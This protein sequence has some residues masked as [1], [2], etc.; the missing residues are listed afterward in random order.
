M[1]KPIATIGCVRYLN[2]RPLVAGLEE[3]PGFRITNDVPSRL[4]AGLESEQTVVAL[5]PVIDY[6]TSSSRL[7]IVPAGAIGS[8][9]ETLTVRAFAD[10][11]FSE[12]ESVAVDGDSRTSVALLQLLL[13]ELYGTRPALQPLAKDSLHRGLPD[14]VDAILLIGD[15]VVTAAPLLPYQLDLGEVWKRLT[16]QPFV[17]ATWM[18]LEATDLDGIPE[19]LRRCREANR[20]MIGRI[21][22]A[23]AGPAGW[24]H[25]LARHYL[26]DVLRY[27]IGQR[28]LKAITTFWTRCHEIGLIQDLRPL[29]LYSGGTVRTRPTESS[30]QPV[31]STE[32]P[33]DRR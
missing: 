14:G 5:C 4:L 11:P 8:D 15:K 32:G 12:V 13:H 25:D 16:G 6:Q 20:R 3:V 17:F 7:R 1:Q 24:P 23:H 30:R 19:L 18:C 22:E 31:T 28:E 33:T 26:G 10:K 9:G 29:Q 27:D 21:A 2:S